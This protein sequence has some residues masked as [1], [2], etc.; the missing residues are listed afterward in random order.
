MV[1]RPAGAA[2]P[3]DTLARAVARGG[4][5]HDVPRRGPDR[6]ARRRR[7]H[8]P[9]GHD[10]DRGP[11]GHRR[12]R[13]EV[14][15]AADRRPRRDPPLDQ[16]RRDADPR[17]S[18]EP[19]RARRR[20][21]RAASSPRCS[22]GSGCRRSSS[23]RDRASSRPSIRATPRSSGSPSSAT[24]RRS[25]PASVR[26]GHAPGPA[27][28]ARTSSTST[29]ARRPRATPSCSPWAA[30]SRSRAWAWSTTG[31]RSPGR[32]PTRATAGS[33]VADGLWVGGRPG[34]T[35]AAHAPGPLPGRAGRA[36]GAGRGDRP[37]L[38][39]A[40][41]GDVHGPGV[42]VGGRD[43]RPGAR[44]PGSTR[45]SA[46]PTSRRARRATRS[47]P[48]PATSRSWSIGRPASWSARRWPARTRPPRSTSAWSRSRRQGEGRRPRRD[49]PRVPEH[50]ADLQR[51]VRGG[52]RQARQRRLATRTGSRTRA[53]AGPGSPRSAAGDDLP[54]HEHQPRS[55]VPQRPADLDGLVD[56]R[57]R[58]HDHVGAV[59]RQRAG[60]GPPR[61]R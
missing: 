6:V 19:A 59:A 61:P 21:D 7:G 15:G 54:V 42:G 4:R 23:S 49:D 20:P 10:D 18:P 8:G 51:A 44:P 57:G 43:P 60:R 34:G 52:P 38:P 39:R 22:C 27:P 58:E 3:D 45:S 9:D 5:R 17:A 24:A 35:G 40:A 12:R 53:A 28:T 55:R 31:S 47:R 33:S 30:S 26:S 16:L 41:A 46:S 14:E 2:E 1:N 48:R 11:R 29:T 25:G 56:R 32:T 50:V 13:L 37:R 36:D